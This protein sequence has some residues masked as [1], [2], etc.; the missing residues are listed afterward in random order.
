MPNDFKTVTLKKREFII[1]DPNWTRE[2]WIHMYHVNN[3]VPEYFKDF[4]SNPVCKHFG[5]F[6]LSE[7]EAQQFLKIFPELRVYY[8]TQGTFGPAALNPTV[9][10]QGYTVDQTTGQLLEAQTDSELRHSFS[11]EKKSVRR[12]E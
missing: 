10:C 1:P 6:I 2:D 12:P 11:F 8:R 9:S 5:G 4:I 7:S 3:E